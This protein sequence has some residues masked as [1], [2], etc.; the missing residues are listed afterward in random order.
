MIKRSRLAT[1]LG[2]SLFRMTIVMNLVTL[3]GCHDT[4][5]N[6]TQHN[7][8]QHNDT[9]HNDTQHYDIQLNDTQQHNDSA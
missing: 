7:G 9:Q 3:Q 8:T 4:Q 2:V 5:N 6:D 1:A